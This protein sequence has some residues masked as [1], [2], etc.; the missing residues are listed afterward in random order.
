MLRFP[1]EATNAQSLRFC[2]QVGEQT[3][4]ILIQPHCPKT[5]GIRFGSGRPAAST[6]A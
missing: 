5:C 1:Q 2:R 3:D 4:A 6:I